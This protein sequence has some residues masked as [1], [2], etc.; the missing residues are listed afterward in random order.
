MALS[1]LWEVLGSAVWTPGAGCTG[2]CGLAEHLCSLGSRGCP[3]G[4]GLVFLNIPGLS[5]AWPPVLG[6]RGGLWNQGRHTRCHQQ[7]RLGASFLEKKEEDRGVPA[8]TS[9]G[10]QTVIRLL[11][12]DHVR[13]PQS[14]E[15]G[16]QGRVLR[17]SGILLC[18]REP[19]QGGRRP[20]SRAEGP[21]C[22][23]SRDKAGR[24]TEFI[25]VPQA[26]GS[27][28]R[29]WPGWSQGLKRSQPPDIT[30]GRM[31]GARRQRTLGKWPWKRVVG[32]REACGS[33]GSLGWEISLLW[34]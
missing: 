3:K 2:R 16:G 6:T 20:A 14:N 13:A 25:H 17:R 19:S 22:A 5:P 21:A 8:P 1:L 12:K 26:V 11:S 31:K 4:K 33:A 10:W 23:A 27:R 32:R 34:G 7:E 30:C 15:D 9:R 29:I 18:R 24:W 28:G